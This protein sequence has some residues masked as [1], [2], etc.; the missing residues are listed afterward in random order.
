MRSL[1]DPL[2]FAADAT[3]Y[4]AGNED[5]FQ[6]LFL[7]FLGEIRKFQVAATDQEKGVQSG[8]LEA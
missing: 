7:R 4:I 1:P 6:F 3:R 2:E 5:H 8:Q